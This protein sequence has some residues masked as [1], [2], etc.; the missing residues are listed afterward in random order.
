MLSGGRPVPASNLHLTLAFL[1]QQSD[2]L[3]PVLRA[4]PERWADFD[5]PLQ[6]DR[7]GYFRGPRIAWAGMSNVPQA[8]V[9]LHGALAAALTEA[10]VKLGG[11]QDSFV[12]HVTLL[13]NALP[14]QQSE[15]TPLVWRAQSVVLVE[16]IAQ[17]DGSQYR[18]LAGG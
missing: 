11:E 13:R 12:P 18:V 7:L 2:S 9:A 15:I 4:M 5:C 8:L 3:L 14:P 10:G 1:G 17:P 6:F 16:S